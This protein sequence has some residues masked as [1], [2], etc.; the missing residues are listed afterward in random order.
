MTWLCQQAQ[1]F[2]VYLSDLNVSMLFYFT[3]DFSE[4]IQ[5]IESILQTCWS[6]RLVDT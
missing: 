6:M 5:I 3:V 2:T 4:K 1:L